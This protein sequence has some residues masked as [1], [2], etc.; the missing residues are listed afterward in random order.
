M[1]LQLGAPINQPPVNTAIREGRR[2]A[3]QGNVT[4]RL[5]DAM[6]DTRCHSSC[7]Y[8]RP[9]T[10]HSC[11]RL[12]SSCSAS[13]LVRPG[14]SWRRFRGNHGHGIIDKP[15]RSGRVIRLLSTTDY[16]DSAGPQTSRRRALPG[17]AGC[18]GRWRNPKPTSDRH[19]KQS[20][21]HLGAPSSERLVRINIPAA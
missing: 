10:W 16:P 1:R 4:S 9:K 21:Q 20:S 15:I 2:F 18:C 8:S 3:A 17:P 13:V 5:L 11:L 6:Y 19:H 7:F 14:D 12:E